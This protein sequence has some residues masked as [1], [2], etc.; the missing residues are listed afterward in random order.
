MTDKNFWNNI[1]QRHQNNG[2]VY[3]I[4]AFQNGQR[5]PVNRFLGI[6]ND[7]ILYIGKATSFAD[8]VIVLKKSISPDYSGTSHICGRRYKLYPNLSKKFPFDILFMELI[9]SNT[10]EEL[11]RELLSKYAKTFG[12]VPPLNA[13]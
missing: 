10:P 12:E 8:R 2:G 3:K 7:G 13:I 11:E 9:E 6:D 1:T 4:I 5:Q